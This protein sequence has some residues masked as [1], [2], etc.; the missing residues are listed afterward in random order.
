MRPGTYPRIILES[1]SSACA[2]AS[3]G[4]SAPDEVTVGCISCPTRFKFGAGALGRSTGFALW[5]L[6][7]RAGNKQAARNMPNQTALAGGDTT[8][9]G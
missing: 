9:D 1:I 5:L 7:S 6:P 4:G 2:I 3:G 8:T